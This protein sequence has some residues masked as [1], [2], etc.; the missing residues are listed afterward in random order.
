MYLFFKWGEVFVRPLLLQPC[1]AGVSHN[2]EHPRSTV[3]PVK[4]SKEPE[5][6]QN[7]FLCQVLCICIIANK[8]ACQ[9]VCSMKVRQDHDLKT[10][11]V[12]LFLQ[13]FFSPRSVPH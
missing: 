3:A 8:P 5:G 7:G 13:S 6:T 11:N 4:A 1:V 2:R 12:V 10:S 9:I